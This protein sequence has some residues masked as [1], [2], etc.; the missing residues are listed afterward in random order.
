[1]TLYKEKIF[2]IDR[3]YYDLSGKNYKHFLLV[4]ENDGIPYTTEY[5][6]F[7]EDDLQTR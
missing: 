2:R 5:M 1:M 4:N 3:F 7:D 6:S